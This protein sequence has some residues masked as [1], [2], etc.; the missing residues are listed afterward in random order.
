MEDQTQ[1]T[2]LVGDP[3]QVLGAQTQLLSG[4]TQLQ[5][6][7]QLV[8]EPTQVVTGQ[9]WQG[10]EETQPVDE[11]LVF[12]TAEGGDE[13]TQAV[14]E[15]GVDEEGHGGLAK[16]SR[17]EMEGVVQ[18]AGDQEGRP[19]EEEVNEPSASKPVTPIAQNK[20][21]QES[22][23]DNSLKSNP[24]PES[25]HKAPVAE[26][27]GGWRTT[28]KSTDGETSDM[29]P[30]VSKPPTS[31][32]PKSVSQTVD[33]DA[34]TEE[35]S[36]GEPEVEGRK[37]G[38]ER[39]GE[40]DGAEEKGEEVDAGK[41][42]EEEDAGRGGAENG[43]GE[44]G[45]EEGAGKKALRE[46]AERQGMAQAGVSQEATASKGSQGA[47]S[48]DRQEPGAS[49]EQSPAFRL[50]AAEEP[51][52]E[53]R[54]VNALRSQGVNMPPV[55][56]WRDSIIPDSDTEGPDGREGELGTAPSV[57]AA[58]QRGFL[59]NSQGP[60]G[61]GRSVTTNAARVVDRGV[62]FG[63]NL[64]LGDDVGLLRERGDGGVEQQQEA[65]GAAGAGASG[66]V[67]V[68]LEGEP[69]QV[70]VPGRDAS[71]SARGKSREP[72]IDSQKS[73]NESAAK[74]GG[75]RATKAQKADRS[76]AGK[77]ARIAEGATRYGES[78]ARDEA[79]LQ[80]GQLVVTD[81][82]TAE[83]EGLALDKAETA[84][85]G[86]GQEEPALAKPLAEDVA[87]VS[88]TEQQVSLVDEGIPELRPDQREPPFTQIDED[89]EPVAIY[90]RR[91]SASTPA[92]R[93][94]SNFSAEIGEE[95]QMEALGVVEGLLG[96]NGLDDISQ[97]QDKG[98]QIAATIKFLG[99]MYEYLSSGLNGPVGCQWSF[100]QCE[101]SFD[102]WDWLG[103]YGPGTG[104]G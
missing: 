24:P 78:G 21:D 57:N 14:E 47:T 8:G 90:T 53:T 32:H 26:V 104:Q 34:P 62:G 15:E 93:L 38:A 43:A 13:E 64:S 25:V 102:A 49:R 10:D 41:G 88:V 63:S 35:E 17:V 51:F 11:E 2:Q 40:E 16:A 27:I 70:G 73:A 87:P 100:P 68:G 79:C 44:G 23:A 1:A 75:W 95:T 18:S 89:N 37:E 92:R 99:C 96:L 5:Q 82:E 39:G 74:R 71:Q 19:L 66:A 83:A 85:D 31:E 81:K 29:A 86:T 103:R 36:D 54:G 97:E 6:S 9:E 61:T 80:T 77:E 20:K 59:D 101:P 50:S 46:A 3:T 4:V 58:S 28:R 60:I 55:S 33:S 69:L 76:E 94:L 56:S 72:R 91:T 22:P 42:G 67:V 84:G 7:T 48:L 52:G 30:S 98:E 45:V 65:E 12:A